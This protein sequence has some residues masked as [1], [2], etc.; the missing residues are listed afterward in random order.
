MS[1]PVAAGPSGAGAGQ[2][3]SPAWLEWEPEVIAKAIWDDRGVAT[4]NRR[5]PLH[6]KIKDL[7]LTAPGKARE[8]I[9]ALT[10]II[11]SRPP[12]NYKAHSLGERRSEVANW[13][14]ALQR[15]GPDGSALPKEPFRFLC[16]CTPVCADK[17]TPGEVSKLV[18]HIK[19]SIH[20]LIVRL[21]MSMCIAGSSSIHGEEPEDSGHIG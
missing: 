10:A 3:G 18:M 4:A 8:V 9:R 20:H 17:T 14:L 15:V 6:A 7:D 19:S 2:A 21:H 11:I 13:G 12:K 1:S 16:L 5:V